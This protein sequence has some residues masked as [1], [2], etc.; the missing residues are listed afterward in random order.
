MLCHPSLL[1][2]S[3]SLVHYFQFHF[4]LEK[5]FLIFLWLNFVYNTGTSK[6]FC[7]FGCWKSWNVWKEIL[8]GGWICLSRVAGLFHLLVFVQTEVLSDIRQSQLVKYDTG[9]GWELAFVPSA[10]IVSS[11]SSIF[12]SQVNR[13]QFSRLFAGDLCQKNYLCKKVDT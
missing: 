11:L 4:R 10:Q 8:G 13:R 7:W 2:P 3:R 12:Y 9:W 1:L 5:C 6:Q